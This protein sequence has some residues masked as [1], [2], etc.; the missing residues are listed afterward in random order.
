M[1][2]ACVS[3]YLCL[4]VSGVSVCGESL[5]VTGDMYVCMFHVSRGFRREPRGKTA[6]CNQ[7]NINFSAAQ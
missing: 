6:C 1:L 5:C 2:C 4:F 3:V 7:G